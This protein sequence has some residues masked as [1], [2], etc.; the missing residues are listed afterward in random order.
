MT[1][2]HYQRLG[3]LFDEALKRAPDE[4]DAWLDRVCHDASLRIEVNLLLIH[5]FESEEFL[6]RPAMHVAATM[7]AQDQATPTPEK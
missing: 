2:E 6:E 3:K 7:L 4:R 1:P 5:H